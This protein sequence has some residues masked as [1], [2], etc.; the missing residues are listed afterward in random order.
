MTPKAGLL[1][2]LASWWAGVPWRFH[3]FTGQ[4]WANKTGVGRA[5]MKG[6][7]R[8][9]AVCAT[10]VFADS[11]SQCRLLEDEGVVRRGGVVVLGQGSVAGVDLSRFRPDP[12]AR[13]AFRTELGVANDNPVFIF[14]GR[15]VRDKGVFDLVEAFSSVNTQQPQWELWVIG[16]D[17]EGLQAAL[18]ARGEDLGARIRWFGPTPNP[19]RY[20]VAA[21]IFVL[22]TYREGFGS[23]IIEAAACGIPSIAYRIDGVIDAIAEG[24]TGLFI[25]KG[26]VRGF[27]DAM[28]RLG[29]E[30]DLS[31]K[32]GESARQRAVANFSCAAVSAAWQEFYSAIL[33]ETL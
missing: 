21:D 24:H 20:M 11:A 22:P 27:A 13:A 12:V 10:R 18:Q 25:D 4:V 30:K 2:M 8:L 15:L 33:K 9:I 23:V 3:T 19:E 17:E 28:I 32:L 1:A 16:P 6:F 5:L 26:D 29:T 14:V 31:A 7:D